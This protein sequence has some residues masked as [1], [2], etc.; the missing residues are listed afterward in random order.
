MTRLSAGHADERQ[1]DRAAILLAGGAGT[2]FRGTGHK[3]L[4]TVNAPTTAT[5]IE[6]AL[7]HAREADI[8]PVIVVTGSLPEPI[9]PELIGDDVIIC[10]NELWAQGQI[11]SVQAGI[12]IARALGCTRVVIGLGDQP[13]VSPD[14]WRRVANDPSPIAVATYN[15]QRGNPVALADETWQLLPTTGDEGARSLIR[16][17][18]DLVS[19][20]SCP[21]SPADIDTTE[22]LHRWQNN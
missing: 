3:L 17:R 10:Q 14:A 8:G 15:G 21:G 4:A 7:T 6:H 1:H 13:F 18:P 19:E 2:R 16:A 9:A 12:E 5:V 22:D 11:T 20:V